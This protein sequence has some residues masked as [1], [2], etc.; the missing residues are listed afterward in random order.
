MAK[1]WGVKQDR[2]ACQVE[3]QLHGPV[4]DLQDI[5][6]DITAPDGRQICVQHYRKD[7]A[8]TGSRE[9][10]KEILFV[11]Q[12]WDWERS[13]YEPPM[14]V[15]TRWV[16]RQTTTRADGKYVG[17]A[18]NHPKMWHLGLFVVLPVAAAREMLS[19]LTYITEPGGVFDRVTID[20]LLRSREQGEE[21]AVHYYERRMYFS[22]KR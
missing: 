10:Y 7:L 18:K 11:L 8:V 5:C 16:R 20:N 4:E 14:A 21:K 22:A 6:F 19:E 9:C 13:V 12:K 17:P 2:I 15:W 1:P 3:P